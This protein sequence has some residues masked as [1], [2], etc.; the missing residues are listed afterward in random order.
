MGEPGAGEGVCIQHIHY[1]QN[2]A[3]VSFECRYT[4][5]AVYILLCMLSFLVVWLVDETRRGSMNL[6]GP[7]ILGFWGD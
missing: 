5:L 4:H 3:Y 7:R 6:K 1:V 2:H